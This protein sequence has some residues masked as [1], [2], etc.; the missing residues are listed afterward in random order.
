MCS[1]SAVLTWSVKDVPNSTGKAINYDTLNNPWLVGLE[2][3][4]D[5]LGLTDQWTET[6]SASGNAT[7]RCH[8]NGP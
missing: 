1:A 2:C 4:N 3:G 8:F 7:L 6:I 5:I